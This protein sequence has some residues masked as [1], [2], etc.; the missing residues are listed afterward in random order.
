MAVSRA[1]VERAG[2]VY[3]SSE[4][5]D[6]E[7]RAHEHRHHATPT[8]DS[9]RFLIRCDTRYEIIDGDLY[10]AKQPS[11]HHQ[12]VCGRSFLFWSSGLS[13]LGWVN[14]TSPRASSLLPRRTSHQTSS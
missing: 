14:P 11:W 13:R 4:R 5:R 12:R 8:S 10:V 2:R 3:W 1:T 7:R 9:K 6:S